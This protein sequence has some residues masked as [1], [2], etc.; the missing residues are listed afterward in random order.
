MTTSNSQRRSV[1][2]GEYCPVGIEREGALWHIGSLAAAREVLRARRETTQAGFT[3]EFI[4]KDVLEHHPILLSDGPLH[5]EQRTK[6]ARFFAPRIV[7]SEYRAGIEQ[8][9]ERYVEQARERGTVD[10]AELALHYAV[11]VTAGIVGL[12]A[13]PVAKMS[14]RLEKFFRQPPLD[15]REPGLGRTRRQWMAAAVNGLTPLG[16]FHFSDVRPAIRE[17]R[18]SPRDDLISHLIA[19]GYTDLDIL[20][21]CV[22]YGTAGMVTTR[23]FIVMAAWHLLTD[24]D[25]R[26]R[27]L[28][29]E[30][31]ERLAILHEIIRLE[32][33]VGH[34][35][36]RVQTEVD[37]AGERLA[38]GD[39]I[40]LNIRA[41]NADPEAFGADALELKPG[42]ELPRGVDPAGLAFGDGVHRCPGQPLAMAET[43]ALLVRL[44]STTAHAISEPQLGWEDL[45]EGYTL[46][47]L[48]VKLAD[49][50]PVAAF[51]QGASRY[52]LMVA[53]NP[54]YHRE[55]RSAAGALV[56]KVGVRGGLRLVDLGCGSGAST[57]ALL[58]AA[59]P[60][61]EILGLDASS[62]M[63]GEARAK[64]EL[65][66]ARFAQVVAGELDVAGLGEGS[67]DGILACYLYRN[68]PA[69]LRDHALSEA[70]ALLKPG[71][72][73]VVH[74][75]SVAGN[76]RA[77][78]IWDAVCRGAIIPLSR[79]ID[80]D[81]VGL[82]RYLWQSVVDFDSIPQFT[83]RLHRAGFRSVAHRTGRGWQRGI[84]HTIRALKP[85]E[86]T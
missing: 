6:V 48:R 45:I 10:L 36:R 30:R 22:T 26:E 33:V 55:L 17:R 15:M 34:L 3:S 47:G 8:I 38:P 67:Y 59:P 65:S 24:A 7:E 71:G 80:K 69:E 64:P 20:V 12:T 58:G 52:D 56:D 28:A 41:A 35:Y 81:A 19:E 21:E 39:L 4:P 76:T 32:P 31:P 82:Y 85:V 74:E 13:S 77:R 83:A 72:W 86:E 16:R 53:L 79:V 73:L 9:A 18:E 57:K 75:Y 11:E 70:W 54:G 42:R 14:R 61:A 27:Y 78:K 25:L 68:V 23:E 1:K 46:R 62:G 2:P 50:D 29:A 60:D 40:D 43:D 44:L 84:L 63:L 66:R 51:D 49:A 37:I 5:D